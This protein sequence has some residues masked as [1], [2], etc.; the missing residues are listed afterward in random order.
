MVKVFALLPRRQD[1]TEEFF[2]QHWAGPHADLAKR[3][4]TLQRYVQSHRTGDGVPGLTPA[5]YEGIAEV[6]FVDAATAAGMGEDPNYAE[7][8]HLDEPKFI[9][10]DNLAFVMTEESV[11]RGGPPVAQDTPGTKAMLLLRRPTGQD[12]QDFARGLRDAEGRL[13]ESVP[14]ARRVTVSVALPD[15]YAEGAEPAY[16]AIV[17]LFFEEGADAAGAAAGALAEL[18]EVADTGRSESFVAEELRVIWPQ[19]AVGATA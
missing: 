6:W 1:V 15:M 4:T 11:V 18:D 17:E 3:I 9:D 16:D 12:P 5:P 13:A 8:A 19:D 14:D 2:H 10:V 7:G